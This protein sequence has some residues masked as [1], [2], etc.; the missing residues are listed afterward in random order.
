MALKVKI[1]DGYDNVQGKIHTPSQGYYEEMPGQVVYTHPL[2]SGTQ[3][4]RPFANDTFGLEQAING[5]G[6]GTLTTVHDGGDSSAFTASAVVGTW[7]FASATQANTGTA[8][9]DATGTRNGDIASFTN[10][11]LNVGDYEAFR[12]F[13]FIES[14]PSSGSKNFSFQL[15]SG[16]APIGSPV[17]LNV[18]VDTNNL[19]NWQLFEIPMQDFGITDPTFDAVWLTVL[20]SG[21]GN[22]PAAYFDDLSFVGA[23]TGGGA[24]YSIAPPADETW[25]IRKMKW[26]AVGPASTKWDEFFGITELTNGYQLAFLNKGA[27]VQ[28]FTAHN[29]FEMMEY[30]TVTTNVLDGVS[31]NIFEVIF[32]FE[33][34][35][36][37]LQ[38]ALEQSI[39]C[40]I[41]D[42]LS[43][44]TK[45]RA[46]AEGYKLEV[47]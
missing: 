30:P 6:A 23:A 8:S 38:G 22:A 3:I 32:T 19:S 4:L 46:F 24:V 34:K 44:I 16:G 13:I 1:V 43:G 26:T 2:E 25:V 21:R 17:N 47:V 15:Y 5:S 31:T 14:W 40:R 33:N 9:I 11:T 7:D 29:L 35:D 42:D 41:R 18:Y 36:L 20:D 45:L 27:T 12:G 28:S 10:S 37:V 39:E